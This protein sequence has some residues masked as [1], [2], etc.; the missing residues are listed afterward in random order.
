MSV[1]TR[2]AL[3]SSAEAFVGFCGTERQK[4]ELRRR[5]LL[6]Q[7][8]VRQPESD[9]ATRGEDDI[10]T[11]AA[12]SQLPSHPPP[13]AA[14]LC[15]FKDE[16]AVQLERCISSIDISTEQE[17][18]RVAQEILS[19]CS[20]IVRVPAENVVES[21]CA[22]R[23]RAALDSGMCPGQ[24]L[25]FSKI[26]NERVVGVLLRIAQFSKKD[27]TRALVCSALEHIAFFE[28]GRFVMTSDTIIPILLH[29]ANHIRQE[30][31]VISLLR[32]FPAF[33]CGARTKACFEAFVKLGCAALDVG[34]PHVIELYFVAFEQLSLPSDF[35]AE[36]IDD[37]NRQQVFAACSDFLMRPSLVGLLTRADQIDGMTSSALGS[38]CHAFLRFTSRPKGIQ[39]LSNDAGR[40]AILRLLM[41]IDDP[42]IC[43]NMTCNLACMV[44]YFPAS[45]YSHVLQVMC[46]CSAVAPFCSAQ[47]HSNGFNIN[48]LTILKEVAGHSFDSV[49]ASQLSIF[50]PFATTLLR[51]AACT[52]GWSSLQDDDPMRVFDRHHILN[53]KMTVLNT[54]SKIFS[55]TDTGSCG[56]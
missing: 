12:S 48:I 14:A 4:R 2:S 16:D 52:D 50:R 30:K 55:A 24:Q 18:R 6:E 47:R 41:K 37:D 46:H 36:S 27:A 45:H 15:V 3:E 23:K 19:V 35:E 10:D 44:R 42:R 31:A 49:D 20:K 26:A 8:R 5:Q 33:C 54:A 7:H 32:I 22:C 39:L 13:A 56:R 43:L 21:D 53:C 9:A 34:C 38:L 17:M 1:I 11:E 51:M 29:M 40:S 25:W 28:S